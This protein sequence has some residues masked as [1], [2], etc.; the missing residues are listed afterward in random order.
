MKLKRASIILAIV[1]AAAIITSVLS[2]FL[3]LNAG[4]S[5]GIGII[6]GAGMP[7]FLFLLGIGWRGWAIFIGVAA[8]IASLCLALINKKRSK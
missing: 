5:G 6:G 3:A 8:L 1:G 7:T 4:T 2:V